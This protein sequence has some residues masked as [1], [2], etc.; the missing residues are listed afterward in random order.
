MLPVWKRVRSALA[1][2][3]WREF[4][5][6]AGHCPFCGRTLLVRLRNDITGVRC[7][8]CAAGVVQL[9]LGHAMR[10]RR[11]DLRTLDVCEL[12]AHGPLADYLRRQARSAALSE[13]FTD[14]LPGEFRR[15]VRCEDV[16]RLTYVD[17]SF[18]L[19]THTEVLEHVPDDA[20]ALSELRRVL[21]PGGTMLFTVPL[22]DGEITL[23]RARV[24]GNSIEHL[25]PPVYHD[26]PL[27]GTGILAFRDYGSDILERL[28]SAGFQRAWIEPAS[29]S[30]V[31]WG[32]GY[33][34]V[35]AER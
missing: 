8:R 30:G 4:A 6:A 9:S 33:A 31:P 18:D 12:S 5:L 3:R 1:L 34:V 13:Y 27:R 19:V 21:K 22:H 2:V 7:V 25:L 35:L 28:R 15:G 14:A 32:Y 23:E 16:Q 26:D 24:R 17:A 10:R 11:S 20:R 29:V